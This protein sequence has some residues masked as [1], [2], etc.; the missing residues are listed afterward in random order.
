MPHSH[1]KLSYLRFD[2]DYPQFIDEELL[3]EELLTPLF[4]QLNFWCE[5]S[6]GSSMKFLVGS[7][8][9]SGLYPCPKKGNTFD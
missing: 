9:L 5:C 7:Q 8:F 3:A 4:R 6:L 1:Q 2:V